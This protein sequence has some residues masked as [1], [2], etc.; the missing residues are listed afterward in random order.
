MDAELQRLIREHYPF[1]IVHAHKKTLA[2]LDDNAQKLKCLIQTAEVTIQFLALVMLAQLHRGLESQRAPAPG[3]RGWSLR[4][5]L[6]NPSFGKWHGILRDVL[7]AYRDH[8]D[9]LVVPEL[10]ECYFQPSRSTRLAVQPLVKEAI[11][12]LIAL[13]NQFHHPGIPDALIPDRIAVGSQ[14]LES[15]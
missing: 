14:W 6:R 11:E 10:F 8:R 1:P 13:R 15:S 2:E 5:D 7:K 4:D 12:P 9:L 3:T